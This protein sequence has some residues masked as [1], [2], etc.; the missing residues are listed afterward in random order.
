MTYN[1]LST[2]GVTKTNAPEFFVENYDTR[3]SD[4]LDDVIGEGKILGLAC[5]D[6]I[7]YHGFLKSVNFSLPSPV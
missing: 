7:T 2:R 6:Q 1:V 5:S 4:I 3:L